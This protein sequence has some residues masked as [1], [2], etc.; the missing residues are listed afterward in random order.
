[1]NPVKGQ[2]SEDHFIAK[3]WVFQDHNF[4]QFYRYLLTPNIRPNISLNNHSEVLG[5][6]SS[7][8]SNRSF[9]TDNTKKQR[10]LVVDDDRD[11]SNLY[12][13]SL[14]HDGFIVYSFNDPLLALSNYKAGA[15]DLLLLDINMPQMNG[16]ELYQKIRLVDDY[17]KV[18]FISAFE[19]YETEF[20][21]L[22]PDLNEADCYIRKP[23]ELESLT[24]KVKSRL[25]SN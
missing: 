17:T 23:I 21:K 15:Y 13:L 2:S 11:I 22:F 8:K 7:L 9:I 5:S 14:E 19:E 10:I 24:K 3:K 16:F 20:R 18:C 12:K 1:M 4:F 25:Q 6:D